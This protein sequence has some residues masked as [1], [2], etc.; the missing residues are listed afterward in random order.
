[1]E[2][3]KKDVQALSKSIKQLTR[4]TEQMIKKLEKLEEPKGRLKAEPK[5]SKATA[6]DII[7]SIIK[8]S[9]KGVDSATLQRKTGFGNQKV[10]DNLYKLSKRGKIKRIDRGVY[11]WAR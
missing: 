1:M 5:P 8:R 7:L 10:R 4:K 6:S 9:R 2:Q 3:L 11:I